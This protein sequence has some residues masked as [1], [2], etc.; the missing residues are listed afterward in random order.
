[1]LQQAGHSCVYMCPA[2]LS[3]TSIDDI[4]TAVVKFSLML[5]AGKPA[6]ALAHTCR[7]A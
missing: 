6:L 2:S 3:F 1:M 5:V 4:M 7:P